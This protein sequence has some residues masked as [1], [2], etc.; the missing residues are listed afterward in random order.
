MA[1]S[2]N[3]WRFDGTLSSPLTIADA[4]IKLID[5]LPVMGPH[6]R[7]KRASVVKL[8]IVYL[9]LMAHPRHAWLS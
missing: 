4:D 2:Q 5:S 1:C 6:R 9:H 8:F 3:V 7:I